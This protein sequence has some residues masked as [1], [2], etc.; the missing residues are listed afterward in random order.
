MKQSVRLKSV[1]LATLLLAKSPVAIPNL[2]AAEPPETE[3]D[4]ASSCCSQENDPS[5]ASPE[6][7]GTEPGQPLGQ[8]AGLSVARASPWTEP[9][10]RQGFD[11]DFK[12]TDQDGKSMQLAQWMGHPLAVSFIFTRCPMPN[13]CPLIT[14]TMARLQRDLESAGLDQDVRLLLVTYDPVYDTPERLKTYGQDRGLRFT[15]ALMLRP[16]VDQFRSLLLEFQVGVDYR[17]DGS[18]GHFIELLLIDRQGRFVRDYQGQVWDNT[19]VLEDLKRLIKEPNAP[20]TVAS[21]EAADVHPSPQ[22]ASSKH[23]AQHHGNEPQP[24]VSNDVGR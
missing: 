7:Q 13:M 14:L 23:Q 2:S 24:V 10:D 8:A 15:N 20:S 22:S 16:D 17:A 4:T 21:V 1:V 3:K 11:L 18:I 6:I 12:M 5:S 19:A 9:V